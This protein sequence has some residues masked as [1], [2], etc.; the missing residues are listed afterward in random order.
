MKITVVGIGYVGLSLATLLAQRHKVTA[1]D[2]DKIKIDKIN[3][4]IPVLDDNGLNKIFA[5]QKLNLI[6]TDDKYESYKKSDIIIIC[7][8]TNYS[9]KTHQF[10]TSVVESS[11]KAA[12]KVNK[13][14]I[15]F[16]KS[17]IPVGF[18]DK[19]RRKLKYENIYFSPEFLRE[20]S[21][22]LDNKK[23]SRII[24]GGF[25]KQAKKFGKLLLSITV[26]KNV[27]VEFMNSKDAEAVKLFSNTYL[28]LRIAFFNE[29]DTY[30]E[31]KDL[32]AKNV[33]KG[34]GLDSRIGNFYN[35][36]SFGYGGYCLPK[37]TQ[38]LL[39][40]Y[41]NVPNNIIKATVQANTTRKQFIADKVIQKKPSVVGIYRLAMKEGSDNFRESAVQGVMKRIKAKGIKVIIYEPNYKK[42]KFFMSDVIQDLKYF[43]NVSDI[44]LAN[45]FHKDLK[46]VKSKVYSRDLFG[47][48]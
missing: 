29:L 11:I 40:N 33:I 26:N 20:G 9:T 14:A 32:N 30:C 7:V 34:I 24:V 25:T 13:R 5:K 16:I 48:D 37:D 46:N 42:D 28:A 17:T 22:I 41:E 45:R 38:Q 8:P 23:P 3:K 6:A 47:R 10:D 31:T 43:K 12:L 35:N 21:A 36:P 44:I 27:P 19:L 2:I 39:K 1:L 18:T 4:K 15:I